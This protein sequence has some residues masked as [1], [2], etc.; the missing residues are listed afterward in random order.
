MTS[1]QF[2]LYKLFENKESKQYELALENIT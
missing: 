2:L 1:K